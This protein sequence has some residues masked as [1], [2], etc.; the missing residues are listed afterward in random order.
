[1]TETGGD[2]L[3]IEATLLRRANQN[4]MLT[5]WLGD[6]MQESARAPLSHLHTRAEDLGIRKK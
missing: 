3:C 4:I 6:L 2:V 5:G 1:M